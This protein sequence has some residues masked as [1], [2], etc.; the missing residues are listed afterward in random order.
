MSCFHNRL[1]TLKK[2]DSKVKSSDF[3]RCVGLI[4]NSIDDLGFVDRFVDESNQ[5]EPN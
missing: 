2:I 1:L 3:Q 5:N 4:V